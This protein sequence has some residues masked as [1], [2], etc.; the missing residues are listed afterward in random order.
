VVPEVCLASAPIQACCRHR[1]SRSAAK[2]S[3]QGNADFGRQAT[4][5]MHRRSLHQARLAGAGSCSIAAG[6]SVLPH[7]QMPCHRS[8]T[9]S[10]P[11]LLEPSTLKLDLLAVPWLAYKGPGSAGLP[12]YSSQPQLSASWHTPP[13]SCSLAVESRFFGFGPGHRIPDQSAVKLTS[14]WL[15][16][17][18]NHTSQSQQDGG[19]HPCTGLPSPQHRP[20][21]GSAAARAR[22]G[23][24]FFA[25]FD[26]PKLGH[27]LTAEAES[28]QCLSLPP[29]N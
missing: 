28:C 9:T 10:Q 4:F 5:G 1:D 7:W 20:A 13:V 6:G 19:M 17:I 18:C 23:E 25:K 14:D 26:V 12:P 24:N 21:P 15:R 11:R 16:A 29:A 3:Q 8:L 2:T 22:C 27:Y